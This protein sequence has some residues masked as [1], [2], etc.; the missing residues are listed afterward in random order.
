MIRGGF[1]SAESA[2]V[3]P[4]PCCD[5]GED[6]DANDGKS[7]RLSVTLGSQGSMLVNVLMSAFGIIT[8]DCMNQS[9]HR[10]YLSNFFLAGE[11]DTIVC[12]VSR[13]EKYIRVKRET[14]I[15]LQQS[16]YYRKLA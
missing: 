7:S 16:T 8:A 5:G 1:N 12:L 6:G 14:L 3:P 4:M 9:Y 2:N 13:K 11:Y 10:R 15:F